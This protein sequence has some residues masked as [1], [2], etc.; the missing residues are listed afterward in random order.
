MNAYYP[1]TMTPWGDVWDPAKTADWGYH[2]ATL[3]P[4]VIGMDYW[5]YDVLNRLPP[6][7]QARTLR[8]YQMQLTKNAPPYA[9]PAGM[10]YGQCYITEAALLLDQMHDASRMVDWVAKLCFAPR[11][12]HP[13]RVPEGSVVESDGSI[14][15]RWGDL[16]NLYQL[17]E[18]EY[19]I[20]VILGID[21]IDAKEL[22]LMPRLPLDWDHIQVKNWPVRTF[23]GGQSQLIPLSMSENKEGNEYTV[24]LQSSKRIDQGKIRIGPYSTSSSKVEVTRNGEPINK[25]LFKSGDSQWVWVDLSNDRTN[26]IVISVKAQ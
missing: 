3:A 4:V 11:L 2:H 8:T 25:S 10:G 7:W 15:R 26:R 17:A 14:W 24:V 6:G 23:S 20:Q 19:T 1:T 21:D 5:G 16:G 9:A 13:Y 18:V 22:V 12:Q